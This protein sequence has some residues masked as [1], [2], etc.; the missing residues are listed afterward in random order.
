VAVRT[1]DSRR[2][3]EEGIAES[4]RGIG[5]ITF[6]AEY[7][8]NAG[9]VRIARK[10]RA[11]ISD[12]FLLINGAV[13]ELKIAPDPRALLRRDDGEQD[14][15]S[16]DLLWMAETGIVLESRKVVGRM[17]GLGG[18]IE[19]T[20]VEFNADLALLMGRTEDTVAIA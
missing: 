16:R 10:V 6:L 17:G 11:K 15:G 20:E 14:H 8:A 9:S 2:A 19:E 1:A 7:T 4:M 18:K 13:T 12:A 5:S 3:A